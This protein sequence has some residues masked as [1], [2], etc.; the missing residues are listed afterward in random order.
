MT[1]IQNK[2]ASPAAAKPL[3]DKQLE[4]S[5]V[6]RA[7]EKAKLQQE[8]KKLDPLLRVRQRMEELPSEYADTFKQMIQGLRQENSS[9][10]PKGTGATQPSPTAPQ[11][12]TQQ[13]PKAQQAPENLGVKS[14]AASFGKGMASGAV[15]TFAHHMVKSLLPVKNSNNSESPA[16]RPSPTDAFRESWDLAAQRY[17]I[18]D[19]EKKTPIATGL[20]KG[21]QAIAD[22]GAIAGAAAVYKMGLNWSVNSQLRN[23]TKHNLKVAESY[24]SWPEK[25]P[26]PIPDKDR[27]KPRFP[28]VR[29]QSPPPGHTPLA[30]NPASPDRASTVAP[31]N[32]PGQ[33]D[34]VLGGKT[35]DLQY[36]AV[37]GGTEGKRKKLNHD[38]AAQLDKYPKTPDPMLAPGHPRLNI[39][40]MALTPYGDYTNA[41]W[42]GVNARGAD[43]RLTNFQT[44]DDKWRTTFSGGDL[45]KAQISGADFSAGPGQKLGANFDGANL[46]GLNFTGAHIDGATMNHAIL[47]GAQP[48][49]WDHLP[50]MSGAQVHGANLYGARFYKKDLRGMQAGTDPNSNK[51][52]TNL[53]SSI[54]HASTL[55]GA[56]LSRAIL[57]GAKFSDSDLTNVSLQ[58]ANLSGAIFDAVNLKGANLSGASVYGTEINNNVLINWKT[59]MPWRLRGKMW[60]DRLLTS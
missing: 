54:F 5:K 41:Q 59:K 36:A 1:A 58:G 38:W 23:F 9:V 16:N 49:K 6:Q 53:T 51:P 35:P 14:A 4:K 20:H 46:S 32:Q 57:T 21:G 50:S 37:I 52:A 15:S 29:P 39:K 3:Q 25:P 13:K 43:M 11:A 48:P 27:L 28:V 56:D 2:T 47:D 34:A 45:R 22:L 33:Y 26:Q 24:G 19:A 10:D 17:Q 44:L 7:Q 8:P 60:L 12:K 30:P 40:G 31:S 18:T 42:E 55:V